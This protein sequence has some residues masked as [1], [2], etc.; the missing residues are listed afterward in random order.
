MKLRMNGAP[1]VF[2]RLNPA[3]YS[4]SVLFEGLGRLESEM[5]LRSHMLRCTGCGV[6]IVGE[7]ARSDFRCV[8]CGDLYQVEYPWSEDTAAALGVPVNRPNASA[9]RYLW[10]ERK[11]SILN[12]DQSGVWRFPRA[13]ADRARRTNRDAAGGRHAAV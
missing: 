5:S 8:Q 6:R 2:S 11:S 13:A 9:L 3:P 10:Q 12:I 7:D 1:E 4:R